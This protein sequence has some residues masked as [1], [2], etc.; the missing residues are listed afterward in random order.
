MHD[1]AALVL[2]LQLLGRVC[3]VLEAADLRNEVIGE[4]IGEGIG[5]PHLTALGEHAAL[6]LELREARKP[7]AGG[8]LIGRDD[9][10]LQAG[11]LVKRKRRHEADDGRAVGVGDDVARVVF[12]IRGV[13]LGD[14]KGHILVEAERVRV[15]HAHSAAL[16]S[17][18]KKFLGGLVAGGTEDDVNALEG[19]RAG[20]LHGNVLAAEPHG[21]ADGSGRGKRDEL[22]DGK[23]TLLETLEH[24][25][26]D[27][28]GRAEDSDYLACHGVVLSEYLDTLG[29]IS[30][31]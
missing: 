9:Q 14:N 13:D 19:I 6:A 7:R 17:L 22:L 2:H 10:A 30:E 26:S 20:K 1:L 23:I 4:L 27:D 15:V 5:L 28:A 25:G 11:G 8:G 21:L 18:G 24:L 16:G 3:L 29:Y 31:S 12:N